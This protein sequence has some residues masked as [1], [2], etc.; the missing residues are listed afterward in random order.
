MYGWSGAKVSSSEG[1]SKSGMGGRFGDCE[2][3]SGGGDCGV[4]FVLLL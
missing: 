4:G 2:G 3:R 1:I